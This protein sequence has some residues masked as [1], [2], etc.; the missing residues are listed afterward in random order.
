MSRQGDFLDWDYEPTDPTDPQRAVSGQETDAGIIGDILTAGIPFSDDLVIFGCKSSLWRLRGDPAY[1]G[2]ND[3][4]SYEIG[5]VSKNAY[6]RGPN[7]ELYFLSYDGI[8]GMASAA[9]LPQSMSR[10]RLPLELV[11]VDPNLFE[12]SMS[13]DSEFRGIHIYLTPVN[14]Q[15]RL[16]WFFDFETKSFWPVQLPDVQQP[17][18]LLSFKGNDA[19]KSCT[20]LG[21]KDGY[22]RY[23]NSNFANDD[24]TAIT[25]YVMFG[26]M[27]LSGNDYNDGK[28][29][30]L[31][32]YVAS[33]SGEIDWAVHVGDSHEDCVDSTAFKTGTWSRAG[34]NPKQ[35]PH[36]R[37]GSFALKISNGENT[38]W[39]IENI[40]CVAEILGTQ[41]VIT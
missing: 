16:H 11:K 17:T 5:I 14:L 19:K 15:N 26:P 1:G 10:E 3:N 40:N 12:I 35:H 34:L 41:R 8:Y 28:L 4:V 30:D 9:S 37:G 32:G 6:C 20:L 22:L 29:I 24:G 31:T 7:G 36:A 25:S 13:Y 39:A 27:R 38:P 21:C 33:E 2:Q 18:A 23:Y